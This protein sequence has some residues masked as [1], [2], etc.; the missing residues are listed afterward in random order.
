MF[1]ILMVVGKNEYLYASTFVGGCRY[2][3]ERPHV[4]LFVSISSPSGYCMP[5]SC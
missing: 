5:P 2:L 1:H 4:M 3:K